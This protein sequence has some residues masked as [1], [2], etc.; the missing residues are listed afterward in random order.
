LNNKSE[1]KAKCAT[2]LRAGNFGDPP[3]AEGLACYG[4]VPCI[5][6]LSDVVPEIADISADNPPESDSSLDPIFCNG[7]CLRS[8]T[9]NKCVSLGG[10]VSSLLGSYGMAVGELCDSEGECTGGAGYIGNCPEKRDIFVSLSADLCGAPNTDSPSVS[11]ITDS[12]MNNPDATNDKI[13]AEAWWLLDLSCSIRCS[14]A[15]QMLLLLGVVW[16]VNFHNCV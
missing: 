12:P 13:N 2:S 16:F 5:N 10:T 3:C 4:N 14:F 7:M 9:V 1:I 11:Q 8:L 6:T 15:M